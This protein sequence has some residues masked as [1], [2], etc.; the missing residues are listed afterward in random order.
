M[1]KLILMATILFST[2]NFAADGYTFFY[3]SE[4][5][6]YNTPYQCIHAITE[7]FYIQDCDAHLY[8]GCNEWDLSRYLNSNISDQFSLT[9][10]QA[11]SPR[12]S[13]RQALR[14]RDQ[15][16]A[17]MKRDPFNTNSNAPIVHINW[18]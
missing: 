6:S 8:D 5:D 1:K 13:K 17:E 16:I 3:Q 14:E 10:A 11:S 18:R 2:S 4:C 9:E 15:K 7:V 12:S